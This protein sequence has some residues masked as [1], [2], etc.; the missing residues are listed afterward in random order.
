MDRLRELN[1]Q[2]AVVAEYWDKRIVVVKDTD[3]GVLDVLR[4]MGATVTP[5]SLPGD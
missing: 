4:G 2:D 3:K 1:Q 5:I